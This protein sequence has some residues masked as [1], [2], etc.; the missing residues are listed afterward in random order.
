[1][2]ITNVIKQSPVQKITFRGNTYWLKRDD[3]MN[4]HFN[5]NK[6]RKF[7]Y[8]LNK[9]LT[10]YKKIA[11]YGGHQSNAMFSLAALAKIKNLQFDYYIKPMPDFLKKEPAGNL[12]HALELGMNIIESDDYESFF[13]EMSSSEKSYNSLGD[14]VLLIRQGGAEVEAE[15]GVKD[16]ADEITEFAKQENIKDLSVFI[17]SGTGTT[18]LFLQKNLD[19]KVYTTPN[20]GD[21]NYLRKQFFLL[22]KNSDN[23]PIILE[24]EKK[25]KFGNLYK[26]FYDV[27]LEICKETDIEFELLYDPKTLIVTDE[28]YN[29]ISGDIM[30]IHSGGIQGN[31]SMLPRYK[32]YFRKFRE[33][34]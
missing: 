12:K 3:L 30:Y 32:R 29:K 14:E 26:E 21:A 25:Y 33:F 34:N 13:Q 20:I 17:Q 5:G 11:S 4:P 2:E 7:K 1:M 24:T 16:M 23:Y 10:K 31:E 28:Y 27:W 6:A 18:A 15:V 9:D 19:F 8:F 22:D